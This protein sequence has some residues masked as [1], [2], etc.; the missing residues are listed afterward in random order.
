MYFVGCLDKDRVNDYAGE[1]M[2]GE[3]IEIVNLLR[4]RVGLYIAYTLT[5][6]P[7]AIHTSSSPT[8]NLLSVS[9]LPTYHSL[10]LCLLTV[11]LSLSLSL[12][13]SSWA[14]LSLSF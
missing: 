2:P 13:S 1:V 5:I 7:S 12:Y 9:F 14:T 8:Y 4:T 3:V 6:Q 10:G 11:Y